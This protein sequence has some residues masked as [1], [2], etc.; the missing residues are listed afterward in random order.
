MDL[1]DDKA[2]GPMLI[3]HEAEPF[4]DPDYI[5]E[6][7]LDGER[8]LAYLSADGTEFRNKRHKKMNVHVP[9]LTNIHRQAKV[10]CILDGEL[11]VM[12]DGAPD[13]S[14]IQRRS[15]MSN[16]FKIGLAAKQSPATFTAFD[17]LYFDG[18]QMTDKPL[19]ERKALLQ[20]AF[21]ENERL[22]LSRFIE[23]QGVAFYELAKAQNLEGIVAKRK[24]SLYKI[25]ARTKDW[26]KIKFLKDEDFVVCG[27]LVKS[28][29]G[30][31]VT[32]LILGAYSDGRL[33]SQGHVTL[34]VSR[35][36]FDVISKQ[37]RCPISPFDFY[38]DGAVYIEPT[39]VCTVKYMERTKN[40]GLRQ[41]VFKGLRFDKAARDCIS[42]V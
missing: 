16:Q 20:N 38:E 37:K 2:I 4:D 17:I 7:K 22:A 5:Y 34:G 40:G 28:D 42:T 18:E 39:L 15:L 12:V 41:P 9:E 29:E 1:F 27:Y 24:D 31:N 30:R 3:A 25:G 26:V 32:S 33:V 6:L 21:D 19:M 10:K 8:C 23:G 14:E 36:E 13:F 11:M 35:Q